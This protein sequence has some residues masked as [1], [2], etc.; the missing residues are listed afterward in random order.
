MAVLSRASS[1]GLQPRTKAEGPTC[2]P[3]QSETKRSTSIEEL[4][5]LPQS[6]LCAGI[7]AALTQLMIDHPCQEGTKPGPVKEPDMPLDEFV[8]RV[9]RKTGLPAVVFASALVLIR[10]VVEV[11]PR[12]HVSEDNA[13]RLFT[14]ASIVAAKTLIDRPEPN[15]VWCAIAKH[16][17]SIA[18]L[19]MMEFEMLEALKY[20]VTVKPEEIMGLISVVTGRLGETQNVQTARVSCEYRK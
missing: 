7:V 2:H 12:S 5:A 20:R 17:Y 14:V 6:K 3:I 18:F 13:F 9:V 10:R 16:S 1:A 19:N 11:T 8:A 15:S 4:E